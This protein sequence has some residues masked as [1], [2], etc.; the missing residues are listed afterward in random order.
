MPQLEPVI[1]TNQNFLSD[2]E[3]FDTAF[4]GALSPLHAAYSVR[5]HDCVITSADFTGVKLIKMHASAV[6]A[7]HTSFVGTNFSEC[8][9]DSTTFTMC[10]LTGTIFSESN[11]EDCTFKDSALNMTLF[12]FTS[13]KNVKFIGCNLLHADFLEAKMKNVT[14]EKCTLE[15]TDFSHAKL[16]NVDLSGSTLKSIRGIAS[17]KGAIISSEQLMS[18]APALVAELG[19]SIKDS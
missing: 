17:L 16:T 19:I 13:L 7:N 6:T 3:Y 12:R 2:K 18:L 1:L 8:S 4:E 15:E 9:L 14:F 10:R 11:L 5:L